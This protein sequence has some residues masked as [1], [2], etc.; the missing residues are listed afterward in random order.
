MKGINLQF[1]NL[2]TLI[3]SKNT[4]NNEAFKSRDGFEQVY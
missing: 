2:L 4:I 3:D 1:D